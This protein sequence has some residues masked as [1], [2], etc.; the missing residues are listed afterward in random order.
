M[1]SVCRNEASTTLLASIVIPAY[2]ERARLP[3]L[4]DALVDDALAVP[5]PPTEIIVVD[6]GSGPAHVERERD[7]ALAAASRLEAAGAPHRVRFVASPTNRGK[8]GAIRLGWSEADVGAAWLGFLDADGAVG[9]RETWRLVRM[10]ERADTFDTLAGARVLMAG[11]AIERSL[12]RHLQGRVFATM[13]ERAFRFGFYDT[14]CGFKLFRAALLRPLLPRLREERWLLDIE[15]LALMKAAGA[16]FREEPIDWSD[17]G[18]SKVVPGVDALKMAVGLW[19][20]RRRLQR[21]LDEE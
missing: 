18:G 20:M 2:R 6:D 19:R 21:T 14:Q 4:L 3:Q 17:P 1:R 10:L 16:R 9:A 7:A 13:T 11:R 5:A 12:F 15:A 8:G